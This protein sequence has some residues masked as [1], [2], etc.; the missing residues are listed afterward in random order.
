MPNAAF[1]LPQ[2]PT[3]ASRSF[4]KG[5]W[6]G[7]RGRGPRSVG[8]AAIAQRPRGAA[9]LQSILAA[10]QQRHRKAPSSPTDRQAASRAAQHSNTGFWEP[11]SRQLPKPTPSH[12]TAG[13]SRANIPAHRP[14]RRRLCAHLPAQITRP[15]D[16]HMPAGPTSRSA[17]TGPELGTHDPGCR[18]KNTASNR[19]RYFP[20]D[21]EC[22]PAADPPG[23][24]MSRCPHTPS[25]FPMPLPLP[26]PISIPI[27][28]QSSLHAHI[29]PAPSRRT[30][31][32]LTGAHP[33][34]ARH[35]TSRLIMAH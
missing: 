28:P 32:H 31:S 16:R 21:R 33:G 9:L 27:S 4:R 5:A 15:T 30:T 11:K 23:P 29:R 25:P 35:G 18:S 7:E 6:A 17:V 14:I 26:L 1:I 24:A 8:R 34:P 19:H 3:W 10:Q 13:R 22:R 2:S 12:P 20:G